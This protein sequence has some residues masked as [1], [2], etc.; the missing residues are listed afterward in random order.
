MQEVRFLV[1]QSLCAVLIQ[2]GGKFVASRAG[3]HQTKR[4]EG[5]Q[6]AHIL[7]GDHIIDQQDELRKEKVLDSNL[8]RIHAIVL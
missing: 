6:H 3:N 4:G 1:L 5:E 2:Q 8:S 7:L